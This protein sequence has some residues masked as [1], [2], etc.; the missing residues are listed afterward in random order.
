M[1]AKPI[2]HQLVGLSVRTS[3]ELHGH[4]EAMCVALDAL[5]RLLGKLAVEEAARI[6]ISPAASEATYRTLAPRPSRIFV[7]HE[8]SMRRVFLQ[9][10]CTDTFRSDAGRHL[11]KG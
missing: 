5:L 3:T 2:S 9:S 8:A 10:G 11:L 7:R 1:S 4:D 6:P